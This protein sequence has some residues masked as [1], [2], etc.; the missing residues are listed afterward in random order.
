M[1]F[2]FIDVTTGEGWLTPDSY[3]VYLFSARYESGVRKVEA[4]SVT[5]VDAEAA[6]ASQLITKLLPSL[7]VYHLLLHRAA[8][9]KMT[10]VRRHFLPLTSVLRTG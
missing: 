4:C 8:G 9:K 6:A 3:W 1:M 7:T 10:L 5:E 2:F